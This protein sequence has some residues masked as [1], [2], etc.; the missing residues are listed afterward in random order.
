MNQHLTDLNWITTLLSLYNQIWICLIFEV[1]MIGSVISCVELYK[2][3]FFFFVWV[4]DKCMEAC[5]RHGRKHL[6]VIATSEFINIC[7]FFTILP[8]SINSENKSQISKVI[9]ALNKFVI[10]RR[11]VVK[12]DLSE[13]TS[14][15]SY[16]ISQIFIFFSQNCK[17]K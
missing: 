16:F 2:A 13:C 12:F 4:N 10:L 5:F 9:F 6:K 3:L 11:N 1:C 15:N 14:R 17:K 7:L 8:F